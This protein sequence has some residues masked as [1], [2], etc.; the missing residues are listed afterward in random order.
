MHHHPGPFDAIRLEYCVLRSPVRHAAH[1][2]KCI[3]ELARIGSRTEYCN[4]GSH[5]GQ[6]PDLGEVK[7]DIE[8]AVAHWADKGISVGSDDAL[9]IDF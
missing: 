1:F 2:L 3:A 4:R 9:R 7:K 5:L 8:G 6:P